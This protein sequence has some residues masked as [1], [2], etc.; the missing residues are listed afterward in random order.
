MRKSLIKRVLTEI[1]Q[2]KNCALVKVCYPWPGGGFIQYE[3]TELDG[4]LSILRGW[5]TP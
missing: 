1:L 2:F 4:L 3:A 5:P